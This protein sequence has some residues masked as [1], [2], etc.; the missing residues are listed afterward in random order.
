[1]WSSSSPIHSLPLYLVALGFYL[2]YLIVVLIKAKEIA[3]L[4]KVQRSKRNSNWENDPIETDSV[5]VA[6]GGMEGRAQ[7]ILNEPK[8]D[9]RS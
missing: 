4:A 8:A 6:D 2:I 7:T 9:I 3:M 1:M 5:R